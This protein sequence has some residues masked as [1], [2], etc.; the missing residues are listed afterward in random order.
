MPPG[1]PLIHL[2][3]TQMPPGA[4]GRGETAE[5]ALSPLFPAGT[6]QGSSGPPRRPGSPEDSQRDTSYSPRSPAGLLGLTHHPPSGKVAPSGS[7]YPCASSSWGLLNL[8]THDGSNICRG[9]PR[10]GGASFSQAQTSLP[11]QLETELL[12]SMAQSLHRSQWEKIHAPTTTKS[13][14]SEA[15]P[16]GSTQHTSG[17][18]LFIA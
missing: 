11:G 5:G 7:T 2:F 10:E 9:A 16:G 4:G 1:A 14:A 6:W 3:S 12:F 18:C 8:V 13:Y 15:M 17:S